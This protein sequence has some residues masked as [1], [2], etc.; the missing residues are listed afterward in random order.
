DQPVAGDERS[1]TFARVGVSLTVLATFLLVLASVS[2]GIAS[3]RAPFGNMYEFGMTGTA[4]AL[5]VYCVLVWRWGIS[6]LGGFVLAI[7]I[8]VMGMSISTYVPAGPLVPALDTYW[9]W[10]HVGSI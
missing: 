2:R 3:Q 6:W 9:K 8:A 4:I 7:S 10:I 5:T 1:D